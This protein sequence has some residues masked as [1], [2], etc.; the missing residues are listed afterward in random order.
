MS[1]SNKKKESNDFGFLA[2]YAGQGTEDM[3]GS[4]VAVPYLA[5]VQPGSQATVDGF[6]AGHWRNTATN[7]DYGDTLKVVVLDFK[8]I[9]AERSDDPN[10]LTVARYIPGSIP[11][12]YKQPPKG[13]GKKGFPKMINPDSG[14][15]IQEQF[16]YVL[17]A[18]DHP[19]DG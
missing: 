7:E 6:E 14:N 10:Q 5:M 17:L 18:V 8:R 19:D 9:W 12:E 1:T 4:A 16:V 3:V 11:V 15:E 13:K 2:Q